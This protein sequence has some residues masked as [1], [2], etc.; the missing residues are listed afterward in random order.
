[1]ADMKKWCTLTDEAVNG[2]TLRTL[3]I[4]RTNVATGVAAVSKAVPS[5]YASEERVAGILKRFGKLQ[6]AKFIEDKL[7]AGKNIR[8]GDLGEILGANYVTAFEGYEAGINR[9]RWKDHREMAM[10][11]DDIIAVR[12]NPAMKIQFLK[13]EVKSRQSLSSSIVALARKALASN[14]NRPAPHALAFLADRLHENGDDAIADLI[15]EAMLVTGI[16]LK[17]VSHLLFT[18][19]GNDP[20]NILR[21]DLNAYSGKVTQISVGLRAPDHQEFIKAVY[22]K[23]ISNGS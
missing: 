23:V 9:L 13:G 5:H 2:H 12:V 7:P 20:S 19:S 1:M 21:K 6:A 10:R 16:E 3:E 11:G 17:Q 22:E 8:S 4:I 18:F 15:D 14:Q